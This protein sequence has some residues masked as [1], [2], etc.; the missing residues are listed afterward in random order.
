MKKEKQPDFIWRDLLEAVYWFD[1]SLQLHIRQANY[2]EMSRTKSL[3]LLTMAQ[4]YGR[5]VQIAEQLGLTRQGVH[6][7]IKELLAEGLISTKPDTTDKRAIRVYFSENDR[8]DEM[9]QF[10]AS[11]LKQIEEALSARVGKKN[12]EVFRKVLQIDWGEPI[13]PSTA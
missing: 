7:A 5:P 8:R 1:E 11:A 10:A 13:S 6:L 9:R 3:I 12:F 2:P 4:G